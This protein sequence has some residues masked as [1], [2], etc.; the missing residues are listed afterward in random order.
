MLHAGHLE[1]PELRRLF[2]AIQEQLYRFPAV[3]PPAFHR[4]LDEALASAG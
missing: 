1:P 3:D 4:A 2:E